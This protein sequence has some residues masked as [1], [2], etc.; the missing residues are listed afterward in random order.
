[1][2][3][4]AGVI[5]TSDTIVMTVRHENVPFFNA[6]KCVTVRSLIDYLLSD[7]FAKIFIRLSER[8]FLLDGF[9]ARL[10]KDASSGDG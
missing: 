3:R 4:V 5:I 9:L 7:L 10:L 1:M 8:S 2:F 6:F